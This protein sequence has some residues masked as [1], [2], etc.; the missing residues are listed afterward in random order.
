MKN[1]YLA[2]AVIALS[3]ITFSCTVDEVAQGPM[4]N[5]RI[6]NPNVNQEVITTPIDSTMMSTGDPFAGEPDNIRPPRK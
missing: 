3:F 6:A 5:S 1:R 4:D 2:A